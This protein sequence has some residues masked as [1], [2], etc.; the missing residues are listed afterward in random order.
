MAEGFRG[1]QNA[2]WEILGE[3][4]QSRTNILRIRL[5]LEETIGAYCKP[6]SQAPWGLTAP[7]AGEL[8]EP[9]LKGEEG[10]AQRGGGVCGA[11]NTF[12]EIPGEFVQ[13]RM[14]ILRI[15]LRLEE[16]AGAYCKPLSQA[17]GLPAPLSGALLE[18]AN[19]SYPP[20]QIVPIGSPLRGSQWE[21]GMER[22]KLTCSRDRRRPGPCRPRCRCTSR[23][24]W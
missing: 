21:R 14:N 20:L 7:L 23:S 24:S 16:T 8:L 1:M 15:R 5:R 9:P 12:W 22:N 11:Q 17:C 6:L 2:V 3:F 19:I 18:R 4:V 13:S 10:R